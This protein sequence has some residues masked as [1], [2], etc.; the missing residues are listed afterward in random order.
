MCMHTCPQALDDSCYP[1]RS[2]LYVLLHIQHSRVLAYSGGVLYHAV[3]Y[4]YEKTNK[5][6]AELLV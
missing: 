3:C 5:G 4:Y 2:I 6:T 1:D